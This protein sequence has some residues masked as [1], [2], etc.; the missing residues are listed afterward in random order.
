[1]D[2]NLSLLFNRKLIKK[3]NNKSI[4]IDKLKLQSELYKIYENQIL[5]NEIILLNYKEFIEYYNIQL[6]TII[7]N[8]IQ[9][10]KK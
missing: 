1:M 6:N 8:F 5:N 7:K 2:D 9:N 4:N 10:I 3:Q